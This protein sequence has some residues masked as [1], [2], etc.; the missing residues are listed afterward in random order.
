MLAVAVPG[1]PGGTLILTRMVSQGNSCEF[2]HYNFGYSLVRSPRIY[3]QA[4]HV[5]N[6]TLLITLTNFL[7]NNRSLNYTTYF[8][9]LLTRFFLQSVTIKGNLLKK[10]RNSFA[11]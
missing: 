11:F 9:G 7:S 1:D 3:S 8:A 4:V 5:R 6:N 2:G 10:G